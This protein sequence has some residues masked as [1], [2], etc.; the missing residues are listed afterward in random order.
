MTSARKLKRFQRLP[1]ALLVIAHLIFCDN[2]GICTEPAATE[3][4]VVD[5]DNAR[6]PK[7][8]SERRRWFEIMVW[9][10]QY[11]IED[12]CA[13][14]GL[15]RD[16]I[17]KELD[18][19]NISQASKPRQSNANLLMLPYPGGK[20]PR[21]DF[22]EGAV[23]PQRETK[24]SIFSPW[25]PSS[26]VVLD[27]PEAIWSNLGLTYLAHSHIPTIWDQQGVAL[28][29][30]EWEESADGALEC[31]RKLP[32]GVVFGTRLTPGT[33]AI[34]MEMWI[35]NG[36]S[37]TLSDLRVQNCALLKF[38]K[39]FEQQ[40]NDNKLF[41]GPYAACGNDARDRWII[42][43]WDPIHRTW[44]N[45]D[46]P[47]LHADP[48]FPDC[49]PGETKRLHGRFSFF[50]GTNVFRE[51]LRIDRTEWRRRGTD[52][53]AGTQV[54]GIV[55][56]SA[57]GQPLPARVHLQSED[58]TWH[59]VESVGG[60][61]VHY[62]RELK[63]LPNSPEVHTTLSA[64]PFEVELP[65]G[66]YTMRV[67]RGK[68]YFPIIREFTI[69]EEPLELEFPLRRWVNMSQRGW[70]SGDTHVHRDIKDLPNVI[71]AE[72]LNVALPLTYWVTV[73]ELPPVD[74]NGDGKLAA[75]GLIEVDA[76]HVIY[77]L[78]TE[79]E[80]SSVG[81]RS[82]TLG[83]V[84]VLNHKSPIPIGAPPVGPVAKFARQ[85]GALFD[86]DKHSWPW[87]L[88]LVPTMG[89]DLFELSNN[90]VWQT[91]FGF[92]D[93]TLNTQPSFMS[94]DQDEEGFTE[95]GWIDYGF[96]MYYSLVNCGFRMRVTAGTASGV[97]PVQ[98]GF[99]RVYVHLPDGFSY[100]SWL[101]GLNAG[102]SFVTTG[103][104]LDVTFNGHPPG[105]TFT[106][107]ASEDCQI[108]IQGAAESKRPLERI[109]I[110][111]NGAVA[112]IL[113]P[114]NKL[115]ASGCYS[116]EID[117]IV[118]DSESF[119]AAVRCFEKHPENRVRFAHTNPAYLDVTDRPLRPRKAQIAYFIQR[120]EEEIEN[121]RNVLSPAA[122]QEYQSALSI[123]Q[124]VAKKAR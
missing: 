68:E 86:L 84:F 101:D 67:E 121:N 80:I 52:E 91:Q 111:V 24:A 41:W 64:D 42:M 46:C 20:H 65:P 95:W 48:Q 123:Y 77:P 51:M 93:W 19:L 107:D 56:D 81:P 62:D 58:S 105:Y 87:S 55:I 28:E 40:T 115:N 76:T 59:F 73:S 90:H 30:L 82:H 54:R 3:G 71:L 37:E 6:R 117:E 33:D 122:L 26:Y 109:E 92:K 23:N 120:M 89:V 118:Q 12:V 108:H 74:A 32:N 43:A 112:R 97:H 22:L 34:R 1:G 44:G 39:G 110:V 98:L 83:A 17:A 88:M 113:T 124:E 102:R 15:S 4:G 75:N 57:T 11:S 2:Y 25:D 61:A 50:E 103:P 38:A 99:G 94:I 119:W 45:Q 79:Y 7:T 47:C 5:F 29:E 66:N 36:T 49:P 100:E 13:A 116:T 106:S 18:R 96:Q 16:F 21:I 27:V 70:Y 85:Q 63:H 8:E 31:E 114:T 9:G 35:T 60:E 78:N 104:M 14:T 53:K 10:H 69:A 72:D